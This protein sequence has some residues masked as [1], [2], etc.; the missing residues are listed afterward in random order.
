MTSLA[1]EPNIAHRLDHDEYS[2]TTSSSLFIQSF[3]PTS[4]M[5]LPRLGR[6][7]LPPVFAVAAL[8]GTTTDVTPTPSD[9]SFGAL[10]GIG[11]AR[12]SIRTGTPN[13]ESGS[14]SGSTDISASVRSLH[15]RS[16]LTWAELGEMLGVSR[17]TLH[18]WANDGNVAAHNA[19]RLAAIVQLIYRVDTGDANRTRARLLAPSADGQT[20]YARFTRAFA[21]RVASPDLAFRPDQLLDAVNDTPDVPSELLDFEELD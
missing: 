17:R 20:L 12:P 10:A 19:R 14:S 16:G 2:A 11:P 15:D 18:N 21:A 13:E 1:G 5:V 7:I 9:Y 8:L 6:A 4:N 3:G